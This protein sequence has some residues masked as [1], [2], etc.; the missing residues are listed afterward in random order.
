M[1]GVKISDLPPVPVAP[2]LTDIIPEVQPAIGGTT[3]KVTF[4]QISNL[5]GIGTL[6]NGQLLIGS[7]GLSPVASTITAGTGVTITNGAGSITIS[8]SGGGLT[9]SEVTTATQ[10][11]SNNNGYIPNRGGGVAF[12]LPAT[13]AQGSMF[14]I[15]GK[16]GTWSITQGAGQ[17]ILV[18]TTSTTLGA[19]G[20]L[21]SA[22]ATDSA[23][24][25]CITANTIWQVLGGPQTAGFVLA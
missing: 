23:Q 24:F 6:T 20:T 2:A 22:N 18:G 3:Y 11:I 9:W 5:F 14:A 12:S 1:A 21:T 13:A 10:V 4:Q 17:Q 16:L 25:I 7:T 8:T 15:V 19:A